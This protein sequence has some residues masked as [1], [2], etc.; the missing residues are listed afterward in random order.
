MSKTSRQ[1]KFQIAFEPC[2]QSASVPRGTLLLDAATQAGLTIDTPCG[3]QGRC[4]RCLVRVDGGKMSHP[5][6]LH[7]T[8][9]Q[10]E[11]GWVI[12]CQ[13]RVSGDAVVHVPPKEELEGMVVRMR[14]SKVAM[15]LACD[16][17]FEPA[18]QRVFLELPPPSLEDNAADLDR[19][20]RA[21]QHRLRS[22][23][24]V[25][26]PLL[27]SL[28]ATLRS[29]G[30]QVSATVYLPGG[31]DEG[32]LIDLAPGRTKAPLL[33]AAVDIG[34]TNVAAKLVDLRGG[35]VLG[36]ASARNRQVLRGEDVIS[37]IIYSQRPGGLEELQ[38]LAV[39]TVNEVLSELAQ[40][41]KRSTAEIQEL[42]VAGNTTMAHLFLG[43]SPRHIREEPYV[44]TASHPPV[45]RAGELGLSIN[46]LAP[47]RAIPGVA[48]YVG[49]D[50]TAGVLSSCLF[51][52][53]RLTLFLDIGTNGEI[54]LGHSDW[55]IT[56]ACSAGPAFE[57]AGVRHGMRAISGAIHELRI[58][59]STLEPT[60]GVIGDGAAQGICGS[61]MISALAEMFLSGVVSRGGRID[62]SRVGT[63]RRIRLGEHGAE[64]V[65]VWAEESASGEDIVLTDVDI[66]NLVRTKAAIYAAVT[67]ML[68]RVGI[69]LS[70][71][72]VVLIG[73][74]FGQ[75]I[76]VEQAIQIGLF[77][78]LPWDRFQFLGNTSLAG[79]YNAL[80]SRHA[81]AV[82][83]E[84]A[85]KLT[86]LELIADNAFVDEFTA[87]LFLPHTRTDDFPSLQ[88]LRLSR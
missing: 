54:V 32:E 68:K 16:F 44:P 33:G 22:R 61:G 29:S 72:E 9:E 83:H 49:G 69:S 56:S 35:K 70:D 57:G 60:I 77:P 64:Y 34:T 26:L 13:A 48:A 75:H 19:L 46:P 79:A 41:Q 76:D 62:Q 58:N 39:D 84:I 21:L 78:D 11:Q 17:A 8:A 24:S 37:R 28:A 45:V 12:S 10:L 65:L 4:G 3:G 7:L 85:S 18:L 20:Q 42:V 71:I 50:I 40:Q 88:A 38:A 36:S 6:S 52:T 15:P 73:G 23:V 31:S 59:S 81:R 53:D 25:G 5:D 74:A 66:D 1:S 87:A 51:K 82:A 2:G 86:Y 27:K 43:L 63:T 14:S 47:V 30:W 67:L 80:V 55:M